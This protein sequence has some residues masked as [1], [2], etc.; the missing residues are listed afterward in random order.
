M[1]AYWQYQA[2]QLPENIHATSELC[3]GE[4]DYQHPANGDLDLL[5]AGHWGLRPVSQLPMNPFMMA[6]DV[7]LKAGNK[8]ENCGRSAT[9]ST[10]Q[11]WEQR[12]GNIQV[13]LNILTEF[14]PDAGDLYAE[15][16]S[17]LQACY[18]KMISAVY[19]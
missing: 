7:G 5:L 15:P 9:R 17:C 16:L 11:S 12:A 3:P 18:Q 4:F 13:L 19:R 1:E 8:E 14:E 2:K 6:Q 10:I